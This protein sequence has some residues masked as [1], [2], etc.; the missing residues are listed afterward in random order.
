MGFGTAGR[1][2]EGCSPP[3][4]TLSVAVTSWVYWKFS[5]TGTPTQPAGAL[6]TTTCT[7]LQARLTTDA[8]LESSSWP[9]E[10]PSLICGTLGVSKERHRGRGSCATAGAFE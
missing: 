1:R 5:K 8:A 2:A 6:Q 10:N 3:E 4:I 9:R 7:S